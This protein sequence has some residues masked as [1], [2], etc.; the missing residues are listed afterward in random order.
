[1]AILKALRVGVYDSKTGSVVLRG[2]EK[3][4]SDL[5]LYDVEV[6]L[7]ASD[8]EAKV[9]LDDVYRMLI[10]I[11][12]AMKVV[13]SDRFAES[14]LATTALL[15][16]ERDKPENLALDLIREIGLRLPGAYDLY[17]SPAPQDVRLNAIQRFLIQVDVF[18]EMVRQSRSF[19]PSMVGTAN[20][21]ALRESG[22]TD[23]RDL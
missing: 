9:T 20:L 18:A 21:Y 12:P 3:V 11:L 7:L 10:E 16:F 17:S 22:G 19:T 14:F 5:Y 1:M 13:P 8:L 4:E 15:A 2:A 6:D 23:R